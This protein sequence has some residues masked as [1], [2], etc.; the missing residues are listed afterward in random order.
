VLVRIGGMDAVKALSDALSNANGERQI[1]LVQALG[2]TQALSG[3]RYTPAINTITSLAGSGQSDL[4]KAVLYSLSVI[5]DASSDK[6]L[7]SAAASANYRYEPTNALENY[8]RYLSNLMSVSQASVAKSSKNL[9]KSTS[10]D[11]Q[12][13]AKTAALEL[14]VLSAGDKAISEVI[15]ALGSKQKAYREAAL[16]F[17]VQIASPK[18]YEALM[19]E[20]KREK[21][22]DIQ[23]ELITA[24][25]NRNDQAA[26][27]FVTKALSSSN[28][29][30][31]CAA[32][33]AAGKLGGQDAVS[34]IVTAMNTD[35]E[36][37]VATG[38]STLLSLQSAKLPEATAAAIPQTSSA[39]A[40]TAFLE[41]LASRRDERQIETVYAQTTATDGTVRL[42][43]A[44][45]LSALATEKDVL[46]IARLIDAA[47]QNGEKAELQNA[48][49]A[50]VAGLP[51]AEQT[52]SVSTQLTA[53]SH[54][55]A[56]YNVLAMIGGQ[57]ALD[58]VLA[59]FNSDNKQASSSA[60]EALTR[61]NDAKV[62]PVLFKIAS[63]DTTGEYFDKA[64]TA[65]VS[66]TTSSKNTPEQKLILLRNALEIATTPGQKSSIIKQIGQTGTFIGLV[67]S[68]HYLSDD[69]KAVQQAA[70]QAV[71]TIALKHPE[72]YGR[73]VTDII[74]KAISVNA[75]AEADYQKQALLKHWESLPKDEGFVSMFN[76]HDLTGW[77]G[78]VENPIVRSKMTPKQLAEKQTEADK[79]MRRDWQVKDG[80]LIFEGKGHDN[81]CSAKDYSDFEMY[82]DWRIASGG[83]AGIYLRGAP[84]VQI[85]D[86]ARRKVGSGGLYNNKKPFNPSNPLVVADNPANEWN[87]FYITMIGEK[88]T[89][90]LNGQLVVD[91]T[92]L[93]NYWDRSQVIFP[94]DAIELQAHGSRVEYRDLYVREIVRPEPYQV[95]D[96]EKKDGFVPLFNGID[97][98]G[99]IG[100]LKDYYAKE[101][102]IVCDPKKGGRG[103]IYTDKEYSDFIMRFDFQLSSGANNGLGIRTPLEGDAA[104][105]GMELQ[106]LDNEADVYKNLRVYQYH[107]SVYG[108]LPSKRGFLKPVGEWN[109][110]EVIAKGNRITVTL[111]G[112]VILDGDIAEASKNFTETADHKN[113]PGLSNKKGY[114]GFLGHGSLLAFR[115]LRIKEL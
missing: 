8:V 82:V 31:R 46:R 93:E 70:V 63:S 94:K 41:I 45:A 58:I 72:Y 6:I 74:H 65:F 47:A 79:I 62:I 44:K 73:L 114:I 84:Q 22:Q 28:S 38:K 106:I 75:D 86:V 71:R 108:V 78:L 20:A 29:T 1:A 101:G 10:E 49:F 113:H 42:A 69:N 5:A 54:P 43:A 32:I 98:S 109:T 56:Y 67:T 68:G 18:M 61:C 17:S 19:K 2:E 110:Q 97:M 112:T 89:V 90:Y 100:N 35:D 83:D 53:S 27:P 21:N 88:V 85:W 37:V 9:L 99:W 51:Q 80:L 81:L 59:G 36:K 95:S 96:A 105:V 39:A 87:S 3:I 66:K 64:L 52:K 30:L 40:K 92:T 48:L 33:V 14:Y 23:A 115:N 104:Y 57:D 12:I 13:A 55:E 34:P 111:N 76:G 60:F 91:N 102:Q 77:K 50:A 103:N 11:I 26:Y 107:G 16:K 25:G 15:A 24:F 4:Q 7:F